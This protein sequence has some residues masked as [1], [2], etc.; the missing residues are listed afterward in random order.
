[1]QRSLPVLITLLLLFSTVGW[2]A[3]FQKGLE[4]YEEKDY[5][6]AL[7]EWR[8]LAEQGFAAAQYN[9]GLM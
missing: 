4:A 7:R 6:I 8:P 5:E 3:D 1:M 9:L 2:S